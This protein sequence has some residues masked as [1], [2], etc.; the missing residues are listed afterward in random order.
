MSPASDGAA[1]GLA[2]RRVAWQILV[3]IVCKGALLDEAQQAQD[4]A[5]ARLSAQDRALA[6][7]LVRT[8]LRRRGQIEALIGQYLN[9]PLPQRA[10]GVRALLLLAAAQV[11][12]LRVPVHAAIDT[13]VRLVKSARGLERF[14]GLVNAVLRRVAREGE[15]QLARYP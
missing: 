2:A 12:F 10:C 5:L 7:Q 15:A 3:R 11:L 1:P 14:A 4:R 6:G 8:A 13:A 9:K